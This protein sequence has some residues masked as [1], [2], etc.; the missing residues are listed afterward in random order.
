MTTLDLHGLL[1]PFI[2]NSFE[3]RVIHLVTNN[4]PN[5]AK[6]KKKIKKKIEKLI[7][8]YPKKKKKKKLKLEQFSVA[9]N[10]VK[11]VLQ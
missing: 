10:C 3:S 7:L 6:K 11:Y 2:N 4:D 9:D 8:L 5:D 1:L